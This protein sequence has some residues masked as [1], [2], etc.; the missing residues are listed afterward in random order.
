MPLFGLGFALFF[1]GL[2]LM[3]IDSRLWEGLLALAGL[4]LVG[5]AAAVLVRRFL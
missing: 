3:G 2:A 4:G 1:A 5:A